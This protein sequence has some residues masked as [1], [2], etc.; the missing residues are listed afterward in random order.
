M[1]L[2]QSTEVTVTEGPFLSNDTGTLNLTDLVITPDLVKLSKNSGTL[3]A[4]EHVGTGAHNSDGE[5]DLTF[6]TGDTD[7]LG[8]LKVSVNIGTSLPV[9][10]YYEVMEASKYDAFKGTNSIP[11]GTAERVN[12]APAS[13]PSGGTVEL[14]VQVNTLPASLGTVAQVLSVNDKTAYSLSADQSGVTIGTTERANSVPASNPT[15][16]TVELAIQVNSGTTDRVNS[17]PNPTAGTIALVTT[18]ADDQSNVTFGTGNLAIEV[19]NLT[20]DG[21][22]AQVNL[23]AVNGVGTLDTRTWENAFKRILA[24][25]GGPIDRST[26]IYAYKDQANANT[27]FTLTSTEGSRTLT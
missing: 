7:T 19:S 10:N 22:R 2:R 20:F 17:V 3:V 16:G 15:G 13:N 26:N 27:V 25:A 9:W 12:S 5:Y 21:T 6:G 4:K 24:G 1:W 14:A 11:V 8:N 23:Q 18:L